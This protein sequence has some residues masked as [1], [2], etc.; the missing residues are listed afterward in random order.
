MKITVYVEGKTIPMQKI[1][2]WELKRTIVVA[3]FL[4]SKLN[5]PKQDITRDK[6][7]LRDIAAIRA[8]LTKIKT[9]AGIDKLRSILNRRLA[10]ST[11]AIKLFNSI[12]G[13]RRTYSV[14][15]ILVEG[16]TAE[17]MYD[18]CFKLMLKNTPQNLNYCLSA[19]P[20]HYIL[21]STG[22]NVQEVIEAPA[23]APLQTQFFI[24]YGNDKGLTSKADSSYPCQIAGVCCLKDGTCIGG[25]RHQMRNEGNGFRAKLLIEFPRLMPKHMIKEH[26]LH[27]ACEFTNWFNDLVNDPNL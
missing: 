20:D 4:Q 14:T 11:V 16:C 25:V 22:E 18:R 1:N 8:D 17:E 23:S 15:E 27:L 13:R 2:D 7:G 9:E 5:L 3:R 26:Q 19:N 6:N 12:C 24:Y 10:V 21:I